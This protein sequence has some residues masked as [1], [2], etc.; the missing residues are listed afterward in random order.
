MNVEK[1]IVSDIKNGTHD[2]AQKK[3]EYLKR[4]RLDCQ[5]NGLDPKRMVLGAIIDDIDG[6]DVNVFGLG[7]DYSTPET[8]KD[9]RR[10][11]ITLLYAEAEP[12]EI[13]KNLRDQLL[14][15]LQFIEKRDWTIQTDFSASQQFWKL[16]V[17]QFV[18]RRINQRNYDTALR[19]FDHYREQ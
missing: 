9:A 12:T 1:M 5:S 15:T 14:K 19:Y 8:L 18:R 13:P 7:Y 6:D 3:V 10:D 11:L 2:W 16:H 17:L 4:I